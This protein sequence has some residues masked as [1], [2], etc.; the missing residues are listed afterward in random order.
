MDVAGSNPVRDTMPNLYCKCGKYTNTATSDH[1][2][3]RETP[4][5]ADRCFAAWEDNVVVKGCAYD[6]ADN[7]ARSYVDDLIKEQ[8]WI[9]KEKKASTKRA[10]QK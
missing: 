4:R 7:F 9:V 3:N 1:I 5:R 10:I 6:A 8:P 2:H